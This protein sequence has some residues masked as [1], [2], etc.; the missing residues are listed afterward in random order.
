MQM[1]LLHAFLAILAACVPAAALSGQVVQLKTGHLLAGEVVRA[2][3]DGLEFRRV[4]NGGVLQLRWDH[5]SSES[6]RTIQRRFR[7]AQEDDGEVL[8]DAAAI[9]Y[10]LPGG[11]VGEVVGRV[12]GKDGKDLLVRTKGH[13]SLRIP[14]ERFRSMTTR[15][16]PVAELYTRDEY[17]REK[18]NEANPGDEAD[19]H[20]LL[21]DLLM[22]VRDYEH[23]RQHLDRAV[24]LGNSLQP[25]ALDERIKRLKLYQERAKERDLLSEIAARRAQKDFAK[26]L[27]LVAT[28]E[29]EFPNSPL[30]P[31]FDKEKERL[32][33]ARERWLAD[34]VIACWYQ[35]VPVVAYAKAQEKG[36]TYQAARSY[37]ETQMGKDLRAKVAKVVGIPEAEVTQLWQ[38]RIERGFAKERTI[39]YSIGSWVLGEKAILKDTA[40]GKAEEKDGAGKSTSQED[41][42]V[43]E[44]IRRIRAIME[45]ARRTSGGEG[46]P[47]EQSEEDWWKEYPVGSRAQWIAAYYAEFSGDAKMVRAYTSDCINCGGRGTTE[48]VGEKGEPKK[49]KCFLC[50]GTRFTRRIRV[51]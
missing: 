25:K 21:A 37:A 12:L 34:Q 51:W 19:K 14:Q 30:K 35:N 38:Q 13:P 32:A 50:H 16:V 2:D 8:V 10:E 24:E 23:A 39:S 33:K 44:Q 9:R 26:A 1:P 15:Q 43:E 40:Q 18:L 31:E 46:Q 47:Q 48:E 11:S 27:E 22:R 29:K 49:I 6:A 45:R 4:D 3:E 36:L 41:K 17:Y 42:Q 28:F 7:I 5:L 20:V